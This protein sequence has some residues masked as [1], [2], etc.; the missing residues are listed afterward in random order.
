MKLTMNK[1]AATLALSIV[2]NGAHAAS[3][4]GM[5]LSDSLTLAGALGTDGYQGA[6]RFSKSIDQDTAGASL[7]TGNV[8]GG[9]INVNAA[10]APSSFTTGF[11]FSGS[12]YGPL[13]TGPINIDITGTTMTVNSLPWFSQSES[14]N[15]PLN[16]PPDSAP[17]YTLV[18]TSATDYAYR[19]K[20]SHY[21]TSADD[22][23]GTFVGFKAYWILEG[24]MTT[25]VPEAS[26]YG[27]MLAGLGLVGAV[28]RRRRS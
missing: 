15:Y 27:M 5:T 28:A 26:T 9:I 16:M 2:A 17:T 22:L 3:V 12:G 4:T 24:T 11:L 1:V 19:M 6:F 20:F 7:F 25:A 8:N 18:Q 10:N 21:I 23:S 14:G 13:T